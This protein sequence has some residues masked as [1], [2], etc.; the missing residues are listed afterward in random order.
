MSKSTYFTGQPIFFL[1]S[2]LYLA[3]TKLNKSQGNYDRYT[4]N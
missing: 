4:K 3:V 1:L 2:S